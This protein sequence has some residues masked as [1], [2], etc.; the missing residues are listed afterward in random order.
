MKVLSEKSRHTLAHQGHGRFVESS[1]DCMTPYRVS[2]RQDHDWIVGLEYGGQI[3]II[4]EL[5]NNEVLEHQT[6]SV[7]L[8]I[9]CMGL[10]GCLSAHVICIRLSKRK[11]WSVR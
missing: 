4:Y 11:L 6:V 2:T 7:S 3:D 1:G 5:G 10:Q 9:L 8:I